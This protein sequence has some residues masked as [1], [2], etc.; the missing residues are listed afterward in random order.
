M[1]DKTPWG[2]RMKPTLQLR[3]QRVLTIEHSYRPK[4]PNLQQLWISNDGKTE[5]WINVPVVSELPVAT[6]TNTP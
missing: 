3:Y 1:T 4:A 2:Q 5:Q 6:S